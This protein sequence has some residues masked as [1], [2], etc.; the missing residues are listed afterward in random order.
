MSEINFDFANNLHLTVR[1]K[2]SFILQISAL[3]DGE[4]FDF[5]NR[6]I[7]VL[8]FNSRSDSNAYKTKFSTTDT[9]YITISGNAIT[10]K[11]R[12]ELTNLQSNKYFWAL[13][14]VDEN[15]EPHFWLVGDYKV[16]SGYSDEDVVNTNLTINLTETIGSITLTLLSSFSQTFKSLENI[17]GTKNGINTTFTLPR[18]Y[19]EDA[20]III[21]NGAVLK[22]TTDYTRSGLTIT[23]I[24][25]APASDANFQSMGVQLI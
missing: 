10:V 22:K 19:I 14:Y 23:M 20:E 21:L 4:A 2:G 7:E 17:V 16:I 11:F 8:I 15:D 25:E 18:N 12:D 9:D 5:N 1:R 24:L 3:L 6:H 13:K